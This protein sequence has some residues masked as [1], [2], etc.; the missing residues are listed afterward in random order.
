MRRR[1]QQSAKS[2]LAVLND[3]LD[4]SKLE[5]GHFELDLAP[6]DLHDL[7]KALARGLQARATR[8]G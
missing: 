6:F 3:I 5:A 1:L 7:V 8:R 4:F 2:L